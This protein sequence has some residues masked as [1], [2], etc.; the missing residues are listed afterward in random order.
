M[1]KLLLTLTDEMNFAIEKQREKLMLKDRQ[2]V[3]KK[4]IITFLSLEPILKTEEEKLQTERGKVKEVKIKNV[5][6][7]KSFKQDKKLT[8]LRGLVRTY[9]EKK[10]RIMDSTLDY[11][12]KMQSIGTLNT[13]TIHKL[14]KCMIEN[15]YGDTDA[16]RF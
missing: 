9:R 8:Y 11:S 14:E 15:Y 10:C 16:E 12:L 7:E 2:E 5:F 1:K 6:A 13:N 3:I 4:I